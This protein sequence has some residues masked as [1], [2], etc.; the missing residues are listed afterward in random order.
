[1][2]E[3]AKR[4]KMAKVSR[5]LEYRRPKRDEVPAGPGGDSYRDDEG[6]AGS[7]GVREPRHPKPLGP[8]ADAGEL[9]LPESPRLV[10]LPDPRR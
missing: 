7:A 3:D 4:P 1:M 8:L 9:P 6:D 2:A 10:T 5:R